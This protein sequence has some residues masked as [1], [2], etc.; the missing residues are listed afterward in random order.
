MLKWV[1]MVFGIFMVLV[2]LGMAMLMVR[3]FFN[4]NSS[5]NWMRYS[6]AVAFGLYGLYRGY[7]QVKGIDYYR[8]R[9]QEEEETDDRFAQLI[10]K[11][12][13]KNNEKV[14]Q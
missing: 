9:A 3:N 11:E 5:L 13:E 10:A 8:G 1:R 12:R 14:Q 4:W 7:R 6:L 2:Y